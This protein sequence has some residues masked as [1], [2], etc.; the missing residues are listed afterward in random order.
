[1]RILISIELEIFSAVELFHSNGIF[2]QIR[3]RGG[4]VLAEG[5]AGGGEPP[6]MVLSTC[7]LSAKSCP[8]LWDLQGL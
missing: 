6:F 2:M 3:L 5:E 1:M 4:G 8:T 7:V